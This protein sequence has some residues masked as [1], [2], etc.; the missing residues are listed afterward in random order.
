M[1][2]AFQQNHLLALLL[3]INLLALGHLVVLGHLQIVLAEGAAGLLNFRLLSLVLTTVHDLLGAKTIDLLLAK[4]TLDLPLL[5][6]LVSVGLLLLARARAD[7]GS[8]GSGLRLVLGLVALVAAI[9]VVEAHLVAVHLVLLLLSNLALQDLL[10]VVDVVGKEVRHLWLTE[11]RD[12][13]IGA[14]SLDGELLEVE[15]I[16]ELLLHLVKLDS[17]LFDLP[18]LLSFCLFYFLL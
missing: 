1:D 8:H 6:T 12:V 3:V 4:L 10:E 18:L 17:V 16:V 2:G 15:N 11:G 14:H 7:S 5:A 13:G 9:H